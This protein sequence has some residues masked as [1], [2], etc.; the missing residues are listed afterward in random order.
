MLPSLLLLLSL[1]GCRS[2]RTV[3][4]RS[5]TPTY[6]APPAG[7]AVAISPALPVGTTNSLSLTECLRLAGERQ[8]RLAA[9]RLSLVGAEDGKRA[10]DRLHLPA[11]LDPQVP[12][13]RQQ[14]ELGLAAASAGLGRIEHETAYAVIRTYVTVLYA[15]EQEQVA[16]SVVE[17]LTATKEIAQRGLDA[18]ARDVTSTDVSRTVVY[19]RLAETRRVQAHEG[20]KRALAALREAVGLGAEVMIDVPLAP[21]PE[22]DI[23]P[24]R[25]E[26]LAAA[27]KNR[28][29]LVQAQLLSQVACLEVDAQK[30][31][32]AQRMSTF[33]AG[34]D[35]HAVQVPQGS[36]GAEY[37]PTADHPEMP[38]LLVGSRAERVKHAQTLSARAGSVVETT[39][40]L[41]IL[42]AEDACLRWEEASEQAKAA[43]EAAEAGDK[44]AEELRKDFAG[45]LK[46]KVEEVVTSRV[47]ASQA[48]SEYNQFL[49]RKLVALADLE[50]VSGGGFRA[51]ILD[52]IDAAA[53]KRPKAK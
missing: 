51:G 9:A 46:V 3:A 26:V 37:H 45:G 19:L 31:S 23:R 35:I 42:E 27:L 17:R 40:N 25:E 53:N 50:R 49:Y 15:R 24:Q 1:I 13:R 8:P 52:A 20:V 33:A 12:Y 39:R 28:G 10:L 32:L 36:N 43:K 7:A 11:N 6:A 30:T 2:S 22:L 18:G 48:R 47:L 5:A 14:A 21:L 34:S 4:D 41:I 38:T 44:L 16:V 29:E